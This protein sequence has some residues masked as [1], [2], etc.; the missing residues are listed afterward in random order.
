MFLPV[1][2]SLVRTLKCVIYG[3]GECKE[4]ARTNIWVENC[5][6]CRCE[7]AEQRCQLE[8]A[9]LIAFWYKLCVVNCT[10]SQSMGIQI[11][12]PYEFTCIIIYRFELG[13]LRRQCSAKAVHCGIGP[14]WDIRVNWMHNCSTR[15]LLLFVYITR[16][17]RVCLAHSR[18]FVATGNA[19]HI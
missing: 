5:V 4:D 7:C 3:V 9:L 19:E 8:A 15:L 13:Y 2:W 17:L 14:P 18:S 16:C 1:F 10:C 11:C 12:L 6:C